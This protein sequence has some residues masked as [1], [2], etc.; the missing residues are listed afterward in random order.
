MKGTHTIRSLTDTFAYTLTVD[1]HADG[2]H[3]IFKEGRMECRSRPFDPSM[4]IN[5]T[6]SEIL[7]E[8]LVMDSTG[9]IYPDRLDGTS[10]LSDLILFLQGSDTLASYLPKDL[11]PFKESI[12]FHLVIDHTID[13]KYRCTKLEIEGALWSDT[14]ATRRKLESFQRALAGSVEPIE[15][16]TNP[17]HHSGQG[18]IWFDPHRVS[19]RFVTEWDEVEAILDAYMPERVILSEEDRTRLVRELNGVFADLRRDIP[20]EALAFPNTGVYHTGSL[21]TDNF[22]MASQFLCLAERTLLRLDERLK[23]TVANT[24]CQ[25]LDDS[26]TH[27]S[28]KIKPKY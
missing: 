19:F 8:T 23:V 13:L 21:A 14:R 4:P 12:V 10:T 26:V 22:N 17:D 2:E 20:L 28:H 6:T 25:L 24:L 11:T 5:L 27:I 3:W 15:I 9:L 18:Q 16:T 7:M 1:R